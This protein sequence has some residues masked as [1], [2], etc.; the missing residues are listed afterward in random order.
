MT[1]TIAEPHSPPRYSPPDA[2]AC[3]PFLA[4]IAE[5][6]YAAMFAPCQRCDGW[7]FVRYTDAAGDTDEKPCPDCGKPRKPDHGPAMVL[8]DWLEERGDC[9]WGEFV[10]AGVELASY[11]QEKIGWSFLDDGD[12]N[13]AETRAV[14]DENPVRERLQR[15]RSDLLA[16]HGTEWARRVLGG[17]WSGVYFDAHG[18][19]DGCSRCNG[20]GQTPYIG[21]FCGTCNGKGRKD[22]A[23]FEWGVALP[24][25]F[26]FPTLAG[27][28]DIGPALARRVPLRRVE[29][30]DKAPRDNQQV[31]DRWY[32]VKEVPNFRIEADRRDRLPADLFELMAGGDKEVIGLPFP[33]EAAANAALSDAA[34]RRAVQQADDIKE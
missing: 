7:K 10:R 33:T 9:E 6:H 34:I 22:I 8:S 25:T 12:S 15:R 26:R 17:I 20:T 18:I 4:T 3:R 23:T 14:I 11:P 29:F 31:N 21:L 5:R 30:A 1:T 13:D 19:F 27:F 16:R 28:T 24:E 2:D 32:W